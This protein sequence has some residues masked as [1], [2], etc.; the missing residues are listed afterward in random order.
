MN[1]PPTPPP[2]VSIYGH[3]SVGPEKKSGFGA[4]GAI[5]EALNP[6]QFSHQS[7]VWALPRQDMLTDFTLKLTQYCLAF[8]ELH[9]QTHTQTVC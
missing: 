4:R 8:P 7:S 3:I 9:T 2:L 1:T 5:A 6:L